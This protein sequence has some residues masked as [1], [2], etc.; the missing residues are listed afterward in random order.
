MSKLKWTIVNGLFLLVFY[1]GYFEEVDGAKRLAL[2]MA[3]VSILLSF[4]MCADPVVEKMKE[5][6]RR[7]PEKL[8]VSYDLLVTCLFVWFGAWIT[9][10]FYLLHIFLQ[11]AAWAK[12]KAEA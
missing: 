3:W 10:C 6:G 9:A 12:A 7:V 4:F 8:S 5:K 11:E 2:F 1:F